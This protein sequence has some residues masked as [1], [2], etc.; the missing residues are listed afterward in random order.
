MMKTVGFIEAC[1]CYT[2]MYFHSA[3]GCPKHGINIK[4]WD[5]ADYPHQEKKFR[6]EEF[7]EDGKW[8]KKHGGGE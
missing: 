5:T 6:I 8:I 1:T 2:E 3:G 4:L 7:S